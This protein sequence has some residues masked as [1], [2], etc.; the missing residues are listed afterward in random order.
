MRFSIELVQAQRA[1]KQGVLAGEQG[2]LSARVSV[3]GFLFIPLSIIISLLGTKALEDVGGK[4]FAIVT[5]VVPV[6][7]AAL[8]GMGL[9]G[10]KRFKEVVVS[11]SRDAEQ[12]DQ[13]EQVEQGEGGRGGRRAAIL[14][15][16]L[17]APSKEEN[18]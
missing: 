15:T 4:V 10:M 16:A 11:I 7:L 2:G 18:C 17:Q 5:S 13:M 6:V 1:W 8:L 14:N 9:L 12:L 3:L